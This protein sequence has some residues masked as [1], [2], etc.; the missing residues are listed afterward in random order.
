MRVRR[1]RRGGKSPPGGRPPRRP[2]PPRDTA[3]PPGRSESSVGD[4]VALR[5]GDGFHPVLQE[6]LLLLQALF[7]ELFVLGKAGLHAQ[8]LAPALVILMFFR[9]TAVF[10]VQLRHVLRMRLAHRSILL[11][12]LCGGNRDRWEQAT[13]RV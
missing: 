13:S 11:V 12:L 4:S 5:S 2:R 8:S 9:E 6:Q 7:L 10:G 3:S 1:W